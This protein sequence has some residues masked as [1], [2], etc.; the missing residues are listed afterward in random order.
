MKFSIIIPVFNAE[1]ILGKTLQRIKSQ[2]FDSS[3]Y[4]IVVVDN[5]SDDNTC[6]LV[7][8]YNGVQLIKED[9]YKNSPYSC[10]NRGIEVAS[11]EYI[12]LL[13]A[14]CSPTEKWLEAY[15]NCINKGNVHILGG[16]V[17]FDVSED[18]S[19]GELSDALNNVDVENAIKS[20]YAM[21]A[22]LLIKQELFN[23]LGLFEE[24]IRSGGDVR[25]TRQAVQNGYSLSYC[26]Q[27]AVIKEPRDLRGVLK[28]GWR[29]GKWM[30]RV[31]KD[32]NEF[33]FPL[34]KT[35]MK[36]IVPPNF[37]K[38]KRKSDSRNIH[39]STA[40]WI[41]IIAM[42]WIEQFI[43]SIGSIYGLVYKVKN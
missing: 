41:S 10:R 3:L 29:V 39:L 36:L 23:D 24:G 33:W 17:I 38:L 14:T 31:W 32:N 26:K 34:M 37:L 8:D 40:K 30:P 42:C 19:V 4:E 20:G 16:D 21:T 25:W 13:D 11:G 15:I 2:P 18:S 43:R 7:K 6:D 35:I 9:E 28:K 12:I 5:G 22:N 27:A 1:N